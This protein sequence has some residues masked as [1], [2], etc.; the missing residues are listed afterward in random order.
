MGVVEWM[1]T[2][3]KLLSFHE[4][5]FARGVGAKNDETY[6]LGILLIKFRPSRFDYQW[7]DPF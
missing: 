5:A 3:D 6:R 7:V 1:T 4:Q 2:D